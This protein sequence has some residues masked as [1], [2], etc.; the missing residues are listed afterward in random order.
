[1]ERTQYLGELAQDVAFCARQMRR[2]PS[3]A[4]I[5]ILTLAL[6]IGATTAIFSALY[7]VVLQ[8]IS[9]REPSRLFMIG[10]TFQGQLSSMSVGIYVDAA[11][12]TQAFEGLA[13]ERFSNV[14]LSDGITPERVLAG[15]VTA[16][17]FGVVGAAPAIGRTFTSEEDQPGNDRVIV[18]SHRLWVRRFGAS[19]AVVGRPIRM[20]GVDYTVTGVM[21]ASMS[22]RVRISRWKAS[23]SS[24]SCSTR[25]RHQT[26]LNGLLGMPR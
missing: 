25:G 15:Y 4:P 5:A 19:A 1:M 11:T 16:N 10:E 6:G 17:F 8:P 26:R 23:S 9:I 22:S 13:A 21:P 12:G 2:S 3:F 18:L 24:T 20:N 14:N 7:A